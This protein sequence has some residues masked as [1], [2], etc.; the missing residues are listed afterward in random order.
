MRSRPISEVLQARERG[1]V[2]VEAAKSLGQSPPPLAHGEFGVPVGGDPRADVGRERVARFVE[3]AGPDPAARWQ[4]TATLRWM[5]VE[6]R[7][8]VRDPGATHK[9]D[10]TTGTRAAIA[11]GI[12]MVLDMPNNPGAPVVTLPASSG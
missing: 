4:G 3:S 1:I 2:L 5:G 6:G 9:E 7:L 10:F 11:G 8:P 12:T